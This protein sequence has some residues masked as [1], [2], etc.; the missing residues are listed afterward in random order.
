MDMSL[1]VPKPKPKTKTKQRPPESFR[2]SPDVQAK[3][4]ELRAKGHKVGPI[5]NACLAL[6]LELDA[7]LDAATER[8][9]LRIAEQE[10][11]SKARAL[12]RLVRLGLASRGT[13]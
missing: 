8:E 2:P 13:R 11:G 12:V 4:D 5:I 3:L 6:A 1:V 9:V 10:G 7:E